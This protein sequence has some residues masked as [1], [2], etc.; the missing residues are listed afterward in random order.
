MQSLDTILEGVQ[1]CQIGQYTFPH[2]GLENLEGLPMAHSWK[3]ERLQ[4]WVALGC[5]T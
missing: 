1:K 3:N 5:Y 4:A 2:L